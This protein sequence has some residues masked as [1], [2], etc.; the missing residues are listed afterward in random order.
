MTGYRHINLLVSFTTYLELLDLSKQTGR[1][2]SEIVR[3]AIHVIL[4]SEKG[5]RRQG[6]AKITV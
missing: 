3:Q 6:K 4:E 2:Y 1:P 5:K